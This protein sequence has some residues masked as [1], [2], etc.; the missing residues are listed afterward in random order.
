[1]CAQSKSSLQ[2]RRGE[3]VVIWLKFYFTYLFA[4]GGGLH[5][6]YVADKT[7]ESQ[8]LSLLSPLWVPGIPLRLADLTFY[9]LYHLAAQ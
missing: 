3:M 9:L 2:D 7:L 8:E 4:E 6:L 5:G 1:M